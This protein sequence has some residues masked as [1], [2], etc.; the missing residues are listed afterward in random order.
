MFIFSLFSIGF[1]NGL[2]LPFFSIS[3]IYN[4]STSKF[5]FKEGPSKKLKK[6]M[7]MYPCSFSILIIW[8]EKQS[9]IKDD[10]FAQK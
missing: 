10:I 6:L 8:K 1:R 7:E 3:S 4:L 9:H 2:L 5:I